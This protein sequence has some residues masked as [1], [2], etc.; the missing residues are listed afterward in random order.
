[1]YSEVVIASAKKRY[2]L[3]VK[4][5]L[6]LLTEEVKTVLRTNVNPTVMKVGIRTL[7]TLKDGQI[8]IEAGTIEKINKL[9]QTIKDKCG[10]GGAELEETVPQL[11]KPRMV[12]N[13][14]PKDTTVDNLEETIIAQNP[15]L[16]LEPGKIDTRFIYTTKK[17]QTN[18]HRSRTRDKKETSAKETE[19]RMADLQCRR[20]PSCNEM[21]QVQ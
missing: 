9:S 13:N 14:V 18:S 10:G 1:L 17:G 16:D 11:R 12:I 6:D 2:K 5:K 4:S 3:M 19:N 8:L 21:L 20:L 15:E 7:K